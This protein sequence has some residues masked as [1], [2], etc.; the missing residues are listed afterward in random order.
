MASSKIASDQIINRRA[1]EIALARW[2][3][4]G[5]R[6]L[7][8]DADVHLD[9]DAKKDVSAAADSKRVVGNQPRAR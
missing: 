2:E 7:D 8:V 5:G 3:S 1:L 9:A 4:E 6:A